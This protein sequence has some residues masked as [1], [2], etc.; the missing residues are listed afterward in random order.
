M[1]ELAHIELGH[2]PSKLIRNDGVCMR[3]WN[4]SQETQAYWV[5]SAALVPRR[6]IKG[7][8]TMGL[9]IQVVAD[10]H[11]VSVELVQFREKVVGIK[12][13]RSQ[14]QLSLALD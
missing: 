13:P 10:K 11:G 7:A 1:E 4:Q 2:K 9:T 14:A 12:L 5:G 8:K 6:A 3:S